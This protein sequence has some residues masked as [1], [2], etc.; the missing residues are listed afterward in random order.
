MYDSIGGN[1]I[2]NADGALILFDIANQATTSNSYFDVI[3]VL[4]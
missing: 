4:F 3:G 2:K 1:Y